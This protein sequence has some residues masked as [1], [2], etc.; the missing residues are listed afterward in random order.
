MI[1]RWKEREP[2]KVHFLL[3]LVQAPP[4]QIQELLLLF[5]YELVLSTFAVGDGKTIGDLYPI[6]A[7]ESAF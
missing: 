1:D 3:P 6:S 5:H 7:R 2:S 4:E